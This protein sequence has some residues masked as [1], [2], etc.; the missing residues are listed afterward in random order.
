MDKST[1]HNFPWLHDFLAKKCLG[2]SYTYPKLLIV[3]MILNPLLDVESDS[4]GAQVGQEH[5][6]LQ[7]GFKFSTLSVVQGTEQ[8]MSQKLVQILSVAALVQNGSAF[9]FPTDLISMETS[10]MVKCLLE[11]QFYHLESRS[12]QT[13]F[14]PGPCAP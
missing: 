7:S 5:E 11:D 10:V 2:G 1:S 12:C 14:T 13:P 9:N 3:C 8:M 4:V 6:I